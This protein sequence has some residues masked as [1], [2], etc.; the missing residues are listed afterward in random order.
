MVTIAEQHANEIV[1]HG[2][3]NVYINGADFDFV[4]GAPPKPG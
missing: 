3:G 4:G 1:V 2:R